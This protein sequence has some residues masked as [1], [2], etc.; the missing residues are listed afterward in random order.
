MAK[1][2]IELGLMTGSPPAPDKIV[3]LKN[4]D[5]EPNQRW[6]FLNMRELIPSALV[7]RGETKSVLPRNERDLKGFGFT[8]DGHRYTLAEMMDETYVDGLMVIHDGEVIFEHYVEGMTESTR[9]IAQ[10]V[11]KSVV[12]TVAGILIG[13][14]ELRTDA[15][16]TDYLTEL[17][18]TSWD[19]CSI[20]NLLDMRT[21]TA[22]DETDYED[23]DSESFRGFR[24]LGWLERLADDPWPHE[25]IAQLPNAAE[26]G[27]KFEYRSILTDV[28]AWCME[29]VTSRHL[30]E[31]VATELWAPMGA[32][33]DADFLVGPASFAMASGGFCLTLGDLAR[34]GL[35][36]LNNGAVG[37]TQVVPSS[38]V[39]GLRTH[40]ETLVDA[41]S[42]AAATHPTDA[43]YHNQ[44]WIRDARAGIYSGYGING[45][46]VLVHQPSRTVV[47]K[48]SSWPRPWIDESAALCDAGLLALC[49]SLA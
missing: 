33:Y 49:D 37:D 19:G 26:H 9:H 29:R 17:R 23:A 35:M 48:F 21:G 47:A 25:Y 16:V 5:R 11:S 46:Q 7:A 8:H 6:S 2:W 36:H 13:R 22:F 30:A 43:F 15:M 45:Q 32:A 24:I 10:S 28:L 12:A 34:F 31:L 3:T 42:G 39:E 38:W 18:G 1:S 20:Q 44:W 14:G 4:Y 27:G 40:D 41:F